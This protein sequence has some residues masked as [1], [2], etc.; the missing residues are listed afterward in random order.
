MITG[1]PKNPLYFLPSLPSGYNEGVVFLIRS[2]VSLLL[3][4]TGYFFEEQL[5]SCLSTPEDCIA[6][7]EDFIEKVLQDKRRANWDWMSNIFELFGEDQ[8][9]TADLLTPDALSALLRA[10]LRVDF[11]ESLAGLAPVKVSRFQQKIDNDIQESHYLFQ[12]GLSGKFEAILVQPA[13]GGP[14]PAIIA[15]PGHDQN[16]AQYL[17]DYAA[18]QLA[19]KGFIVIAYTKKGDGQP[20]E[21]LISWS[22]LQHGFS[23]AAMRVHEVMQLFD[24]IAG[25]PF[26][27]RKRIYLLCHSGGCA[28]AN[29]IVNIYQDKFKMLVTDY[30]SN[31][32]E[33]TKENKIT[34]AFLPQI[35][36]WWKQIGA[37]DHLSTKVVKVHYGFGA[38]NE[39]ETEK[40]IELL[41]AGRP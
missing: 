1:R 12:D 20:W 23:L 9:P 32:L 13:K 14:F 7:Y 28:E 6:G 15:V 17:N 34:N 39:A 2:A 8:E 10:R 27:D 11:L 3:K 16:A 38:N 5:F 33:Y 31:Y 19:R 24:F 37:F 18:L 21:H 26:V 40:L 4:T 36:D 25:Q 41:N 22:F 30:T 29:L 35:H